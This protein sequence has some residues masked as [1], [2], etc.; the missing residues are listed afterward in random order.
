M[1]RLQALVI[2]VLPPGIS[3]ICAVLGLP[4]QGVPGLERQSVC[5]VFRAKPLALAA[6]KVL[7][8]L[9]DMAMTD[10]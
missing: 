8:T 4:P 5:G 10:E 9:T 1:Y 6:P 7:A 3:E 2:L